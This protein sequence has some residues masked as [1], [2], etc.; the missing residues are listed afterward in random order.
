MPLHASTTISAYG[1]LSSHRLACSIARYTF[2]RRLPFQLVTRPLGERCCFG[3]AE[4]PARAQPSTRKMRPE[5]GRFPS[6]AVGNRIEFRGKR[7]NRRIE[8][9]ALIVS[10]PT[11]P[12][13]WRAPSRTCQ[14]PRPAPWAGSAW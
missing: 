13:A 5:R 3:S 8:R 4:V 9:C 2:V 7:N 1:S 6:R 14:A 12:R 10:P 11:L